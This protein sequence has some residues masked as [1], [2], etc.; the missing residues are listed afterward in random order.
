MKYVRTMIT[1]PPF[2]CWQLLLSSFR[3]KNGQY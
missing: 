3:L 1:I 2:Y